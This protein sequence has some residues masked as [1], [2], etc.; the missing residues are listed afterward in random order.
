MLMV[1][2]QLTEIAHRAKKALSDG[3]VGLFGEEEAGDTMSDVLPDVA[4]LTEQERIAFEKELLGFYL[5]MHPLEP[6]R[7]ALSQG[8]DAIDQVTENRIGE[9]VNLGGIIV[10]VKKILTKAGNNEMAFVRLEDFSGTI[11]CVVFPKV[12][13][14]SMDKWVQDTVVMLSGKIDEKDD[15][16]TILVDDVKLLAI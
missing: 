7:K 6:Y 4:E 2:P 11:E 15:R 9:R 1:L 13:A 16:M 12:Y 8:V 5:T 10:N 3:Q 14:R